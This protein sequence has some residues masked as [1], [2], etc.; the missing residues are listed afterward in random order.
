MRN[1]AFSYNLENINSV[2]KDKVKNKRN[3]SAETKENI[4]DNKNIKINSIYNDKN[5]NLIHLTAPPTIYK[6]RSKYNIAL[7][8]EHS[9]N[10]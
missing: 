4:Q 3:K 6:V 8:K 9:K 1:G 10:N 2:Y 5:I 7:N